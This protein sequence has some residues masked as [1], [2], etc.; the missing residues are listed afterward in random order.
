MALRFRAPLHLTLLLR[1]NGL[2][3]RTTIDAVWRW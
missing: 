2:K 1:C 3:T